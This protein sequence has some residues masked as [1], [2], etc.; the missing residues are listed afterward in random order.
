MS[1]YELGDEQ[2]FVFYD[3]M[4]GVKPLLMNVGTA[5]GGHVGPSFESCAGFAHEYGKGRVV[6]LGSGITMASLSHY[7]STC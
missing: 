3:G 6:Y 5:A 2:H 7:F 4:R 1:D